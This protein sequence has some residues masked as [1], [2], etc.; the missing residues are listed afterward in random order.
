MQ[1]FNSLEEYI[2]TFNDDALRFYDKLE[3]IIMCIDLDVKKKLF[4]GQVA[5]YVEENLHKTFHSSPVI[6]MAFF[7]DHVN[8]FANANKEY[9]RTLD[10][11]N[12]T[13]KYTMQIKYTDKILDD[14]LLNL[15]K[16]SLQ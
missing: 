2:S 10:L 14:I 3:D 7:K 16:D 15:F 13:D 4:A 1:K 6:V 9:S 11:Y 12:F 5:F 8:I